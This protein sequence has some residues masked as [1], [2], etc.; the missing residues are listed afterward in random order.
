MPL[1]YM[2]CLFF[3]ASIAQAHEGRPVYVKLSHVGATSYALQWKTPPVLPQ[4]KEPL[5]QLSNPTCQRSDPLLYR[6]LHGHTLYECQGASEAIEVVLEYPSGNPSLSTLLVYE[7]ETGD[8]V[9][10]IFGPD[11]T[12]L[13]PV[14]TSGL[15][16]V[17]GDY[18]TSGITHI[19]SGYDHLL[20]VICL[21][22]IA[23]GLRR[24]LLT[25]TGFTIAHSITLALSVLQVVYVPPVFIECLIAL[26]IVVLAAEV[27]R[28]NRGTLAWR[29]PTLIAVGFGLLHGF[30][31]ASVLLEVG[32]PPNLQFAALAFF[33]LGVELGQILFVALCLAAYQLA[34]RGLRVPQQ[35]VA[36]F[37]AI[38]IF[39]SGTIAAY[40]LTERSYMLFNGLS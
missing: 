4:G 19:L 12:R 8:Q 26:S 9:Q 37:S 10:Q 13:K 2:V 33:N 32:L 22:F 21:L 31:F 3:W 17:A 28:G 6:S 24:T 35:R 5:I 14:V 16:Q 36:A 18:I 34:S 30:G 29:Y 20:F 23:R 40:W 7:D 38:I 27:S 39:A 15:W 1:L 25:I 11:Q